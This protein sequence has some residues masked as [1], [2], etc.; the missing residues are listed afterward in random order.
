MTQIKAVPG[1]SRWPDAVLRV[2]IIEF[3]PNIANEE[4]EITSFEVRGP[5]L[6]TPFIWDRISNSAA[7]AMGPV[8]ARITKVHGSLEGLHDAM[9]TLRFRRG[10]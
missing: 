7:R 9:L 10:V 5:V 2:Q 8:I 3:N 4:R 1:K 6:S